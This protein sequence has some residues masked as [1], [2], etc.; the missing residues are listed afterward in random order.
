MFLDNLKW[1]MREVAY[2][3]ELEDEDFIPTNKPHN[4]QRHQPYLKTVAKKIEQEKKQP[5]KPLVLVKK[6]VAEDKPVANYNPKST[7]LLVGDT[8]YEIPELEA[9]FLSNQQIGTYIYRKFGRDAL[10]A[11]TII[12]KGQVVVA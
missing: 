3:I 7:Y 5:V 12:R 11:L 1:E 8:T 9:K 6:K 2:I 4:V 10:R